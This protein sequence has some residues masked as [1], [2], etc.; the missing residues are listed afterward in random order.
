MPNQNNKSLNAAKKNKNDEFYTHYEDVEKEL[1]NYTEYFKGKVIYLPCDDTTSAFWLYFTKNFDTIQPKAIIATTKIEDKGMYYIF[2]TSKT[3]EAKP[4]NDGNFFSSPECLDAF[5]KCDIVI[6]N[7]PFSLFRQF[8]AQILQYKKDFLII[9]NQNAFKYKDIFP[10]FK[11]NLI[12]TGYNMVKEFTQP[13]GTTK[14]F[15]NV[16]WFTNLPTTRSNDELPLKKTY[17]PN[18]YPNISNYK[19]A[20][21]VNRLADIP[22]DWDGLMGVPI[23]Y[24]DKNNPNQFEIIDCLQHP[25]VNGVTKYSRIIIKKVSN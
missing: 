3:Y 25:I 20:I 23:T 7:P 13:D 14:K 16:C 9:G 8:L 15:G 12:R 10:L 4:I 19:G 17:N 2:D 18:D 22:K 6:T 21:N 5:E 11:D 24:M 1:N